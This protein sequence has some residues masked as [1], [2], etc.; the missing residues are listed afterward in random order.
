MFITL[1]AR[2][3][4]AR[5]WQPDNVDGSGNGIYDNR[6]R[7]K[8]EPAPARPHSDVA[9]VVASMKADDTT[10]V[11]RYLPYGWRAHKYVVDD[12]YAPL[13]VPANKGREAMVYLTHIIDTY[14]DDDA[15]PYVV[16]V[17][18]SRF[19][20]HND[21]PDYDAVPTLRNLQ[22]NHV[23]EEGYVNLRCVWAVGCPAEIRPYQDEGLGSAEKERVPTAKRVYKAAWGELM[24]GEPAPEVVAVSCCSQFAVTREMIRSRPLADYVHFRDWLLETPL[25]DSLSGRVL[26]FSWHSK[27]ALV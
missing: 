7:P 18:A 20:W 26:E 21:D 3:L 19:A 23:R 2:D 1:V 6:P 4:H 17:H 10:W 16:F 5:P 15:P 24:H 25:D 22:L 12:P 14:H 27:F 13:T 11:D 9:L 8:A